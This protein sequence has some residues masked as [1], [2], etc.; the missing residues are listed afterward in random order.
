MLIK[1]GGSMKVQSTI[2]KDAVVAVLSAMMILGGVSRAVSGSPA[3]VNLGT[4]GNFVILSKAGISTTGTTSIFGDAGV[5]PIAGT[6]M[7]GFG[8]TMDPSNTFSTS[9]LVNGKMYAANY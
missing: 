9:S 8:L 6:A 2:K 5:S 4:A 3:V 1:Q 7:T